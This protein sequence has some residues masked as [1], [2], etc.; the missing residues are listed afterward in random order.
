MGV[1][2]TA[3]V[4]AALECDQYFCR[5][6]DN[7]SA[8][9]CLRSAYPAANLRGGD[10]ASLLRSVSAA[11]ASNAT[12]SPEREPQRS[13]EEFVQQVRRGGDRQAVS[14]L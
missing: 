6:D 13:G 12:C 7:G 10:G 14:L 8:E 3:F 9:S 5:C 11:P 4:S 2:F 1:P